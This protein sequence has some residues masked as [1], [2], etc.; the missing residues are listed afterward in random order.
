[1]R[2]VGFIITEIYYDARSHERKIRR[3]VYEELKVC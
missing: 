3:L 2:V 1:V